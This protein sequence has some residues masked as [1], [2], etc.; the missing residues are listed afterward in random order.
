MSGLI[1]ALCTATGSAVER[2]SQV[3]DEFGRFAIHLVVSFC[4]YFI[5]HTFAFL[6]FGYGGGSVAGRGTVQTV[7]TLWTLVTGQPVRKQLDVRILGE[8]AETPL[9]LY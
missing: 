3:H 9:D 2:A 1:V 8:S 6:L 7:A 5:M 4:V